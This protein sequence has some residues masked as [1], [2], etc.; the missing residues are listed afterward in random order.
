MTTPD[1]RAESRE[2]AERTLTTLEDLLE[3][4]VQ[5]ALDKV[6]EGFAQVVREAVREEKQS[7]ELLAALDNPTLRRI[8]E[9]WGEQLRPIL[10][11]LL[12][13]FEAAVRAVT[14][15]FSVPFPP[16]MEDL[17]ER[18]LD[19]PFSV[20]DQVR[21][22][23]SAAEN[24]LV[25]VG[26]RLWDAARDAL[27][28]GNDAGEGI[29]QIGR[30]LRKVFAEDGV[31]LGRA[32]AE[33]IARTEVISVWNHASLDA[34]QVLPAEVR[35]PYKSWLATADERTRPAH[36]QADAATVPLAAPFLVGGE[37]LMYPGDPAG[38]PSNVIQC[39]CAVTFGY[40]DRPPEDA[41]R[42]F[43][44]DGEIA[45]VVRYF[46]E[47][48][49][50][51]RDAHRSALTAASGGPYEGGMVALVPSQADIDRLAV[52]DGE[53]PPDLH[54]TLLFLGSGADVPAEIRQQIVDRLTGVVAGLRDEDQVAMPVQGN[55]FALSVFNP[56]SAERDT[57][58]VLGVGGADL[59]SVRNGV[60][61]AVTELMELPEQHAPWVPHVTL[62][63]TDDLPQ[64]VG[65]TDRTGPITFD[66]LQ[67]AF[68]DD[69]TDIPLT[70]AEQ[71]VAVTADPP[72]AG[73]PR[74]WSTPGD[75]ALAWENQETGDGRIFAPGA[76][77]WEAGPWPLQYADEMLIGHEG[78]ELAGAIQT[79]GRD[80]DRIPG[81]GLL[82]PGQASGAAAIR[83]LEEDAPLG[84]SVDLDDV[85]VELIDRRPAEERDTG[86]GE[87]ILLASLAT[88]SVLPLPE[89][90][91]LV[92]ATHVT[93][94]AASGRT[95]RA[96]HTVEW[97]VDPHGRVPVAELRVALTASGI[98]TAAAGDADDSAGQ[99]LMAERSG[100][101]VMRITRGR[102]RGATLVSM[103][104]FARARITLDPVGDLAAAC[105][106]P[107]AG[108]MRDIVAYVAASP[109]PVG[110]TQV[111]D[112]L[113]ISTVAARDYLARAA[114]AGYITRLSRG[115]YVAASTL[116]EGAGEEPEMDDLEASAWSEFQ[117]L[118]PLPAA[119]FREPEALGTE[120]GPVH[121]TEDG[122]I[123]GWVAQRGVCHDG[124]TGQ[125]VTIDQL[126]DVDTSYFLRSRVKL[127]DGSTELA[128]VFTMN[129]GHDNDGTDA[130]STR[131]LFDNTRTVAGIVTVGT[132]DRGM[133]FSGAAAPWLSEWDRAVFAAC[134][135]SGHWRRDR[136]GRWSL[137]AVLSVP[138]PGYPTRLAASAVARANLALTASAAPRTP[139]L[140]GVGVDVLA[141]AVV[142]EMERRQAA[143]E[144][145]ER[146]AAE[147]APVR[148]E[149]AASMA[150]QINGGN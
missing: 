74:R 123:Y 40:D 42:Q 147:L 76:L 64:I 23:L 71:E 145:I 59:Q 116:P 4:V 38:S 89:G 80:G 146:L 77:Y 110:A 150:T 141:S 63:Y 13:I 84:V 117:A 50:I 52:E 65:L 25:G 14:R 128:G 72:T 88:A 66:R 33:R 91:H 70:P 115:L 8:V 148:A 137:R 103:P 100:D 81:T 48:H 69:I 125:C 11:A 21:Q 120:D 30:R 102:V 45:E 118:P 126:G 87:V 136:G 27:V 104:A 18:W 114:A 93:E 3:A 134:A 36:W 47:E 22:Y 140:A 12:A 10:A 46:E 49:G 83:L 53:L 85:D 9:L 39:R 28:E 82:Y 101:M 37:P 67:V 142:D 19:D 15:R 144:E 131:A 34:A 139:V 135:P 17:P 98:M 113:A 99:V 1:P 55:G 92:R 58:I 43:L 7:A 29:D 56:N 20:L 122:R 16:D 90:G 95:V 60:G 54:L 111:A 143:R 124:Y 109:V 138:V 6:A 73:Q 107:P 61:A 62:T 79:L 97:T 35:P 127:D 106:E 44:S 57:C 51:V 94:Q 26:D 86:E 5:R 32:R 112:A 105:E 119:W 108:R 132:N 31:E 133:W 130:A 129:T 149:I 121:V 68:G 2:A 24:R 41:G 96:A 78:A 75:T